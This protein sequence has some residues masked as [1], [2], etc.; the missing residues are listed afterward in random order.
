MYRSDSDDNT[1]NIYDRICFSEP[2][3]PETIDDLKAGIEQAIRL[4]NRPAFA[5][6]AADRL[7]DLG[8]ECTVSDTDIMLARIRER[9]KSILGKPCPRTV[10]EWI[11]GTTPGNTNRQNNYELCCALE[12]DFE[13]T[14][15]FFR[16]HFL[17]QPFNP[18]SKTDAVFMY[19]LFHKKPYETAKKLLESSVGFVS[20][21]NAHTSTSRIASFIFE[22]ND[23]EKFLEYLSSHCYGSK[24]QF[25]RARELINSEITQLKEGLDAGGSGK[26][27]N[28]LTI[29]E[30]LG[31]RYQLIDKK[32]EKSRLPKGFTESLPN[33]VT[34][35]RIINGESVS[36]E[37]LRKTL[38]LLKFYN[39]YSE[40]QNTDPNIIGGNLMDLYEEI[41]LA[42][43]G[44]G[45]APIYIKDPFDCLLFFCANSY[46]PILSLHLLNERN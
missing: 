22:I 32:S 45:F 38:M 15:E 46:D 26:R 13:Q 4:E 23:D 29:S 9:Y 31:Y 30:L 6:G 24:Q 33:D 19:T 1:E 2:I 28:S 11:R 20:D 8:V 17:T 16:K 42:L 14:A 10:L 44:C 27:L 34:L 41:D 12:M 7:N 35:G 25:Q 37:L 40:A 21:E 5:Q 36:Y 3:Y 39:F 43:D 18:K